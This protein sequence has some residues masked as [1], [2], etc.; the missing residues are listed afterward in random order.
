MWET[1]YPRWRRGEEEVKLVS[2]L[3]MRNDATG[4]SWMTVLPGA[5]TMF[6]PHEAKGPRR[7]PCFN[8]GNSHMVHMVWRKTSVQSV[9]NKGRHVVAFAKRSQCL[10]LAREEISG[11]LVTD[12]DVHVIYTEM[13]FTD[14]LTTKKNP[15]FKNL[16]PA[17]NMKRVW[18]QDTGH[19]LVGARLSGLIPSC[20]CSA[21]APSY[22]RCS[23]AVWS[24][25]L[26][27]FFQTLI[28]EAQLSDLKN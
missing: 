5:K 19:C 16:F 21:A 7:N 12:W 26:Q 9:C 27:T 1:S 4:E 24:S 25:S 3:W 18:W 22:V 20:I 23:A 13:T 17:W 8:L 6:L 15:H 14:L 28:S 11:W 10:S 2:T